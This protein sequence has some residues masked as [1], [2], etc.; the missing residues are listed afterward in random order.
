MIGNYFYYSSSDC[1]ITTTI[2]LN[3]NKDT[4]DTQ[5]VKNI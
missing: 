4:I 3:D 1:E 5:K 2:I